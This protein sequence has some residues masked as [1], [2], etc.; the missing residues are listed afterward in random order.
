MSEVHLVVGLVF[1]IISVFSVFNVLFVF[2]PPTTLQ[3][4]MWPSTFEYDLMV[5]GFRMENRVV[6]VHVLAA[7]EYEHQEK[8]S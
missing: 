4:K 1:N 3:N 5:T 8:Q 6:E 7:T 2:C